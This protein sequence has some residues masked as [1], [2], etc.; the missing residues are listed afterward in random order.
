MDLDAIETGEDSIPGAIGSFDF[1]M[2]DFELEEIGA[3]RTA[4]EIETEVAKATADATKRVNLIRE[5]YAQQ[6][7]NAQKG[8]YTPAEM[9]TIKKN[10]AA[11]MK[12]AS[13]AITDYKKAV[14]VRYQEYR[15][16]YNR[17]EINQAQ[18][19]QVQKWRSDNIT[20]AQSRLT[21][22][23][24][25]VRTNYDRIR[26]RNEDRQESR[27]TKLETARENALKAIREIE[28]DERKKKE[29]LRDSLK[30]PSDDVFDDDILSDGSLFGGI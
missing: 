8:V 19:D 29:K 28:R 25:K 3:K 17:R 1:D 5:W 30:R 14:L 27:R 7:K 12:K 20:K 15:A 11:R 9:Q 24:K 4:A 23:K 10:H 21:K 22:Y 16:L 6:R 18:W 26:S 2:S 13:K